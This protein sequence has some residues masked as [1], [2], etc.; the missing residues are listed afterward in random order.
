MLEDQFG[1]EVNLAIFKRSEW[2]KLAK[3]KD[4]FYKNVVSNNVLLYEA[5]LK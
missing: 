3:D 5:G 2:R 1:K 4:A